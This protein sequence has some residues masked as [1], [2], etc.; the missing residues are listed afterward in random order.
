MKRI[1]ITSALVVAALAAGD[2]FAQAKKIYK[3]KNEKGETF[4]SNSFDPK[5]CSGGGAQMNEAGIEVRAIERRKTP[6]ELAAEREAIAVAA[7]QE[8]LLAER[9]RQDDVLM[10]SYPT[11]ADL[12]R[13][14]ASDLRGFDG[15]IRT[16]EMSAA[17]YEAILNELLASAA[18]S[19]RAG[20]AVPPTVAKRI[21]SVRD[22]LDTQRKAIER[23]RAERAEAEAEHAARLARYREL[24]ARQLKQLEGR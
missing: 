19:E 13:A 18:E 15:M 8:R 2:A 16:Q 24:K 7:E 10:Q 4:Y 1:L 11:E 3:C 12:E 5:Q 9:K 14:H 21:E 6:E 23:R 22:D 20:Q 17:S